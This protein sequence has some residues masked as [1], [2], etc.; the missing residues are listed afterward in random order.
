MTAA[1]LLLNG[2]VSTSHTT[3]PDVL[4]VSTTTCPYLIN[5][6]DRAVLTF[7]DG[8]SKELIVTHEGTV[9]VNSGVQKVKGLPVAD[10]EMLLKKEFP[11]ATTVKI[12]EFKDNRISVL[13]E[14]FHQLHT[15]LG[16]GPMRLMDAIAAANGF[17]PLADK[18][19]VR[20]LR[21]NAGVVQVYEIDFPRLMRGENMRQNILV[22]PGDVITVPRNFL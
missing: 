15:E 20:L 16:N 7:A 4:K 17:T 12:K 13:G 1:T 2:C 5:S 21:E 10:F 19:H 3:Q 22:E 18:Q 11:D 14:V 6:L 8:S 9:E